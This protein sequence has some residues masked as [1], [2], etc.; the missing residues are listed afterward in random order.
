MPKVREFQTEQNE[1]IKTQAAFISEKYGPYLSVA[2]ACMAVGIANSTI[3]RAIEN[4]E[5]IVSRTTHDGK[6]GKIMIAALDIAKY[7]EHMRD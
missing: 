4:G 7:V 1:R 5:I 3:R 2:K 6:H